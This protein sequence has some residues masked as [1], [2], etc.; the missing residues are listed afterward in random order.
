MSVYVV[1]D[2]AIQDQETYDR[3]KSLAPA[4]I[5]RYGGRYLVRGGTITTL[6]GDWHPQRLVILEFP[7]AASAQG[8]WSSTEY[9]EPKRMRQASATTRMVMI[10]GP[11]FD[12][13]A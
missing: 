12:P 2:I 9:A 3:Y 13:K 6:E 7:D 11:S 8:W 5:A 1:V 4:S 10:D